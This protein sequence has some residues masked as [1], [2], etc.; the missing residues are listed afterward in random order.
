MKEPLTQGGR[1]L[2]RAVHGLL[3]PAADSDGRIFEPFGQ[4]K[5]K[6]SQA[7]DDFLDSLVSQR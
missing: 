2:L 6:S 7:V 3:T 4:C 1:E 5:E